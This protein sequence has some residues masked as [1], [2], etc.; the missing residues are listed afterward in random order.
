MILQ[1]DD[2]IVETSTN[3]TEEEINK[4]INFVNEYDLYTGAID[5]GFQ[6][7]K[8]NDNNRQ[9]LDLL[10]NNDVL[11][12]TFKDFEPMMSTAV[13]DKVINLKDR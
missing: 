13:Y 3:K 12:I 6:Y 1:K 10:E 7:R 8:A 11:T 2:I 4:I 9:L 5:N